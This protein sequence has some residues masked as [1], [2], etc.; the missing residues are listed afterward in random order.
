MPKKSKQ[1]SRK[2]AEPKR[3][4]TK[5]SASKQSASSSRKQAVAEFKM[6]K[7]RLYGGKSGRSRPQ[8]ASKS[9]ASGIVERLGIKPGVVREV[10]SFIANLRLRK[11][12]G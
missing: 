3:S 11:K 9:S 4:A 8:I 1:S 10:D 12:I 6:G 7:Y 5:K 2:K